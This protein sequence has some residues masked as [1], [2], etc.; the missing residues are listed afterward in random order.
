VNVG[1]I[2]TS[3]AGPLPVRAHVTRIGIARDLGLGQVG[4]LSP[5][6]PAFGWRTDDGLVGWDRFSTEGY[7]WTHGTDEARVNALV[8]AWTVGQL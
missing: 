8:V 1:D 4:T 6:A 2:I 5:N 3:M 7:A